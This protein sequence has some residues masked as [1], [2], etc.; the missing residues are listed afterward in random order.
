LITVN[1]LFSGVGTQSLAFKYLGIPHKVVGMA[2]IEKNAI[3]AYETL[4][5][6]TR[7]YGDV[8]A[9]EKLDYAD[10]WT[11]SFPCFTGDT[12]VLTTEGWKPIVDV[13]VGDK[14]ITHKNNIKSVLNSC[15]TGERPILRVEVS[16]GISLRTTSNHKFYIR[17]SNDESHLSPSWLS[18]GAAQKGDLVGI[19]K[20]DLNIEKYPS[21]F[22]EEDSLYYWVEIEDVIETEEIEK[23]Y[24][25]EVED[26]HSFI[27]EGIAVHNCQDLSSGGKGA[28]LEKGTRSGL[29]WEVERLLEKSVQ[30]GEAPKFLL[31]E[32]V[33]ELV[34]NKK[35]KFG[36]DKWLDKLVELG[37][38]NHYCVLNAADCG[39]PQNRERLFVVSTRKDL[40]RE[41]YFFN[42]NK[43][44][45]PPFDNFVEDYV[46][47]YKGGLII[48]STISPYLVEAYERDLEDI[49]N[50]DKYKTPIYTCDATVVRDGVSKKSGF[51]DK[52]VGLLYAPTIRHQNTHTAIFYNNQIHKL[53]AK[54]AWRFMG[55]K[56]EDYQ[57]VEDT[58]MG[59]TVMYGLAGNAIVVNVL[60][61]IY[62][63]LF[64]KGVDY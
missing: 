62:K 22:V 33:P 3:K 54:E 26:D 63:I 60:M 32:N 2:E 43:Q 40:D 51:Q 21:T 4:H 30:A 52:R 38:D 10:F 24:D 29:L 49:A 9:V 31:L 1:E 45:T 55:I 35:H 15:F 42:I 37:Y 20:N 13:K 25:I 28:G 64:I 56:D 47:E 44:P 57:K 34:T 58:G 16:G 17:M 27:A 14:V 23:V 8:S 50:T 41:I 36:L 18:I 11:Y 12:L 5:G 59:K 48:D 7:N 39:V 46:R 61:E 53:T 6:E 19:L